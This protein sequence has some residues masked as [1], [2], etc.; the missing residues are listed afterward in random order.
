VGAELTAFAA[1][2]LAAA[3]CW[4][5][6][7]EAAGAARRRAP[8]L[9][10]ACAA[11]A[12]AVIRAGSE[13]RDPGVA[14]RRRLLAAGALAAS[15]AGIFAAG[16]LV[17]LAVGA[18][19]PWLVARALRARRERYRRAVEAG[20]APMALAIADALGAGHSLRGAIAAA[21]EHLP[22][23]AGHELRRVARELAMGAETEAALEAMRARCRSPAIE[24]IVAAALLQRRAGGD[25]ATLLRDCARG[26]EDHQRLLGEVRAATAQA[27][28]TALVVAAL[29]LAGA[30]LAELASP[31]WIAGLLGSFVTAWL[32]GVA[33]V[34]QLVALVAIR[35]LG[36]AEP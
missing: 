17:G 13:G 36:R 24:A 14:E 25:L 19:G 2:A 8:R 12:D 7:G 18:G 22:G 3:A 28:F 4:E 27:R 16:P 9:A 29:P 33:F 6:G 34:L 30:G 11:L 5:L 21:A 23:A 20:A 15:G 10:R 1:G 35:R 31:G 32:A 26:F